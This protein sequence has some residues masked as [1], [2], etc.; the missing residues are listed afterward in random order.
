[1]E[2]INFKKVAESLK[3]SMKG[4]K[5]VTAEAFKLLKKENPEMADRLMNDFNKVKAAKN[6]DEI[7][8]LMIKYANISKQ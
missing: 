1:M 7:N 3:D 5:T 2:D 8:D 6:T 4:L